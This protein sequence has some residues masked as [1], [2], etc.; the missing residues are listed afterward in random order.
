[1]R[2]GML[3][4][5]ISLLIANISMISCTLIPLNPQN[6]SKAT[7]LSF[8]WSGISPNIKDNSWLWT[9][10]YMVRMIDRKILTENDLK[11]PYKSL[12]RAEFIHWM[13][14]DMKKEP[15]LIDHPFM[16]IETDHPY[17]FDIMQAY[18]QGIIEKTNFFFPDEPLLRSEAA[19]WLIRAKAGEALESLFQMILEPVIPAQD[20]FIESATDDQRY[21]A[22]SLLPE[23]QL[24]RYRWKNG[25]NFRYIEANRPINRAEAAY[26]LYHLR[27]PPQREAS[28]FIGYFNEQ[29]HAKTNQFSDMLL[30]PVIG[31]RDE[32]WSYYPVLIKQIPSLENGLWKM[33]DDGSMEVTFHFREKLHWSDGTLI[34][35]Y[36]AVYAHQLKL[37]AALPT[38]NDEIISWIQKVEAIDR[39]T[40]KTYWSQPYPY[41]NLHIE[42]FPRQYIEKNKLSF[43]DYLLKPLHAGPY[44][45]STEK[46]E[47]EEQK[48]LSLYANPKYLLGQPLFETVTLI[49]FDCDET[50]YTAWN[51]KKLHLAFYRANPLQKTGEQFV[52][53]PTLRW[54]HLDLSTDHP[55]LV[56]SSV[57]RALLYSINR[58]QLTEELFSRP[59]PI[60]HSYFPPEHPSYHGE[61]ITPT[62]Y[63]L[64]K[65]SQLMD[66]AGWTID[67]ESQLRKKND[68]LFEI[69]L[70]SVKDNPLRDKILEIISADWKKLNISVEIAREDSDHFFST[71]LGKR[72]FHGATALLYSWNFRAE[73]NLFTVLHSSMVPTPENAYKGQNYSGFSHALVDE[74]LMDN[75]RR[76][77]PLMLNQNLSVVLEIMSH[78]LAS[79]PLFFYPRILSVDPH[80][81]TIHH[82]S[83]MEKIFCNIAWWYRQ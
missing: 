30:S 80:L 41:A 15:L 81:E 74:I 21:L 83:G 63:D 49:P 65:A 42:V 6:L 19:K 14:R 68:H 12:S 9:E 50:L 36:D 25:S 51:N 73:S 79:L 35:A 3:R 32:Q 10:K 7:A 46:D 82:D 66:E 62:P 54:E 44:M 64:I 37:A 69:T 61:K 52:F 33:H 58:E 55:F 2:I 13:I 22:L 45:L 59:Y 20:G 16:D 70:I 78:E 24:M 57:R 27:F 72:A 75:F 11:N 40:Y 76:I 4:F 67:P 29:Q 23:H 28:L 48:E 38:N 26:G 56:D 34:D 77:E 5:A 17:Y 39:H 8:N 47:E 18:H 31:G 43:A 71:I 60:A 1:M 53:Q